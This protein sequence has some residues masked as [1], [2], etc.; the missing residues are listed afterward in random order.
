MMLSPPLQVWVV[1]LLICKT[2]AD[3]VITTPLGAIKGL[4]VHVDGGLAVGMFTGIEYATAERWEPPRPQPG[5]APAVYDATT[6]GASC[7]GAFGDRQRPVGPGANRTSERCLFL[8]V[9]TPLRDSSMSSSMP[10]LVWLHGGGFMYGSG[11]ETI[12]D[13]RFYAARHQVV[14]VTLNYRLGALGFLASQDVQGNFGVMDQQQALR[15]VQD[16]IGAFGGD[17]TRVCIFGQSAGGMSVLINYVSPSAKGLFAKAISRS[18]AAVHYRTLAQS[19]PHA[20]T[21]Y[22]KLR[23]SDRDLDCLKGRSFQDVLKA[24]GLPEYIS[25]L[26][27]PG[28]GLNFLPWI[29][30]LNIPQ[31]VVVGEPEELIPDHNATHDPTV[32]LVIGSTSNET[33]GFLPQLGALAS[34]VLLDA[35]LH[36]QFPQSSRMIK[37][38]YQ[39]TMGHG[40]G[41]RAV[42]AVSTD[43]LF[44]WYARKIAGLVS[45]RTPGAAFL[46]QFTHIPASYPIY[47]NRP[48]CTIDAVCHAADNVFTFATFS[49]LNGVKLT[50][51]GNQISGAIMNDTASFAHGVDHMA[52]FN[53][54]IKNSTAYGGS[55]GQSAVVQDYV[56][57]YRAKLC[58]MWDSIY[59]RT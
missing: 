1:V 10:V 35:F 4:T 8:N 20:R 42:G 21:L 25:H 45:A 44:T 19:E 13:G 9:W 55:D 59:E 46:Y 2:G 18:P 57:S 23:C 7:P 58:D 52:V 26:K 37:E 41:F 12:Y 32:K 14:V 51:L 28:S 49:L 15:W 36:A 39:F 29:P 24:Q 54:D 40:L 30:V 11:S 17:R 38:A 53:W 34:D 6:F 50:P 56:Q 47:R 16:N 43:C 22:R 27:D 3:S 31:G 48:D 5:W 33:D